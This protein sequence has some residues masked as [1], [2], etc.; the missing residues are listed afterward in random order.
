M[1]THTPEP[2]GFAWGEG[3]HA[4]WAVIT[5]KHAGMTAESPLAKI[6]DVCGDAMP[7]AAR[8]VACVNY[9]AGIPNER[10]VGRSLDA[11]LGSFDSCMEGYNFVASQRN[12]LREALQLAAE[13]A[14]FQYMFHTTQDAI[15]AALARSQS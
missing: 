12:A 3:H 4:G 7:D 13:S 11:T 14:G 10:L 2:W 9:C 6:S 8:I 5:A 15:N 1:K